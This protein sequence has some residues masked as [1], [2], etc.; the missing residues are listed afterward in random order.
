MKLVKSALVSLAAAGLLAAPVAAQ[1]ASVRAP[2]QVEDSEELAGTNA[3]LILAIL[4]AAAALFFVV[5]DDDGID[6]DGLPA[7]P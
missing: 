3:I 1:A 7:S 6:T 4:A 5:I 2:S